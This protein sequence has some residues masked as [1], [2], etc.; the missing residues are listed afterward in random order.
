MDDNSFTRTDETFRPAFTR[1]ILYGTLAIAL[2]LTARSTSGILRVLLVSSAILIGLIAVF[3]S[4]IMV[5]AFLLVRH[6][7]RSIQPP[8]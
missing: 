7:R 5:W 2:A 1:F 6:A 3:S 4:A 8:Q